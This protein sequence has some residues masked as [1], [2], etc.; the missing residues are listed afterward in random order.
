[1]SY[2]Q[3]MPFCAKMTGVS[4]PSSGFRPVARLAT[5]VAFKVEITRSCGPSAAGSSEAFT[6]ALVSASADA[7]G[8]PARFDRRQMRPA[9][10]A[11]DLM[12]G[13]RQPHRKMAADGARAEN[14]DPHWV[15]SPVWKGQNKR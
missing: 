15:E 6:L 1:M 5:P 12:A 10:H 13:L 8:E 4:A 2:H 7:K 3:G 11:G 9:H 14:T